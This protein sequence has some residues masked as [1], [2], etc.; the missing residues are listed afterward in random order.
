MNTQ[1]I[2]EISY[3]NTEEQDTLAK[4]LECVRRVKKLKCGQDIL[5]EHAKH[6]PLF[7]APSSVL[8]NSAISINAKV[9]CSA[10]NSF[11]NA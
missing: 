5:E 3:L 4:A 10:F 11:I 2:E 7:K 6:N 1:L 8:V 9:A